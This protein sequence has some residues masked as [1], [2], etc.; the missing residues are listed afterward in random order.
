MAELKYHHRERKRKQKIH[1]ILDI[2]KHPRAKVQQ[3]A[4]DHE[5][6][7]NKRIAKQIYEQELQARIQKNKHDN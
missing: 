7:E 5:F 2:L 3:S 4:D 1:D 6:E